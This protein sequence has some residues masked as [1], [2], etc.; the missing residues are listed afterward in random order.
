MG[1]LSVEAFAPLITRAGTYGPLDP[2]TNLILEQADIT[3]KIKQAREDFYPQA[4][5][6]FL[7]ILRN[8]GGAE[9][10][11]LGIPLPDSPGLEVI[12]TD[13][14]LFVNR[15]A[16]PY[17]TVLLEGTKDRW[18]VWL[19]EAGA[20]QRAEVNIIYAYQIPLFGWCELN[21]PLS[22]LGTFKGSVALIKTRV[23]FPFPMEDNLLLDL[24]P[25]DLRISRN[26]ILWEGRNLEPASDLYLRFP[27]LNLWR[28]M[29]EARG[30][31]AKSPNSPEM[32][33]ILGLSYLNL[34]ETK[35]V[36]KPLVPFWAEQGKKELEKAL[37][38]HPRHLGAYREL[39]RYFELMAS[40]S[41]DNL[42]LALG[43]YL[44]SL[45]ILKGAISIFPGDTTLKTQLS[46]SEKSFKDLLEKFLKESQGVEDES[47][48]SLAQLL[49]RD[50]GNQ[51]LSDSLLRLFLNKYENNIFFSLLPPAEV[52]IIFSESGLTRTINFH[53]DIKSEKW[54]HR[55]IIDKLQEESLKTKAK[56]NFYQAVGMGYDRYILQLSLHGRVPTDMEEN[57]LEILHNLPEKSPVFNTPWFLPYISGVGIQLEHS[58][59]IL[60]TNYLWSEEP[61]PLS[62][63]NQQ[64]L[65][66]ELKK[67]KEKWEVV[68]LE[69]SLKEI[70]LERLAFFNKEVEDVFQLLSRKSPSYR[71]I[72]NPPYKIFSTTGRISPDEFRVDFKEPLPTKVKVLVRVYHYLTLWWLVV[73]VLVLGS[74]VSSVL[75]KWYKARKNRIPPT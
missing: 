32:R 36:L 38:L 41:K 45:R 70:I 44:S 19:V 16:S 69:P 51:V 73:C 15:K 2:G 26:T 68:K 57:R 56:V 47:A 5:V 54:L 52:E 3:F 10:F 31:V 6:D 67:E 48:I 43:Y 29:V 4:E 35:D 72:V 37:S 23:E 66:S 58:S 40:Y 62:L 12:T 46:K 17:N 7:F 13:F 27:N 59:R 14:R 11:H 30:M 61:P 34:A 28:N 71:V 9:T 49:R 1:N 74:F 20:N 65:L 50:P 21:Y 75:W 33:Y 25:A 18:Q 24:T 39:S 60:W 64:D 8:I 63:D 22:L 55:Q 53:F 42:P